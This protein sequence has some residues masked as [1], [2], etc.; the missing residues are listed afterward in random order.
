MPVPST[1][2][3]VLQRTGAQRKV[4]WARGPSSTPGV[5]TQPR[6]VAPRKVTLQ[7]KQA[8]KMQPLN[9]HLSDTKSR[10][11]VQFTWLPITGLDNTDL[12]YS[13]KTLRGRQITLL[14]EETGHT[15]RIPRV[16]QDTGSHGLPLCWEG[17]EPVFTYAME[18]AFLPSQRHR[19]RP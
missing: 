8:D 12:T 7:E 14:R 5:R 6:L 9:S 13:K 18:S 3:G 16:R 10:G 11:R 17:P 15:V 19:E 1:E 2:S 4:T